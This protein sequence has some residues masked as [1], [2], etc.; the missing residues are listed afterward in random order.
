M[1][2]Y[3]LLANPGHNRV[4]FEQSKQ[5]AKEELALLCMSGALSVSCDDIR[6][7]EIAGIFYLTFRCADSLRPPDTEL[8]SALSFVYAIFALDDE[9]RFI[10]VCKTAKMYIDASICSILKYTGKTNEIFTKLLINTALFSS[11]FA[12]SDRISLLD[13]VAGKGTTLFEGLTRGYDVYGTEIS[14]AS[15]HDA[16]VYLKKYLETEKIKHTLHEERLSGENKAFRALRHTFRIARS[17]EEMKSGGVTFEMVEGSAAYCRSFYKKNFFHIIAGDLPYGIKH[18]NVSQGSGNV[19]QHSSPTRNPSELTRLCA[20]GWYEVLMPGGC[21]AL[22][23]NSFLISREELGE[24]LRKA[25]F[26]VL[27][28]GAYASLEHRVD[29]S[30][31]RDIIVAKKVI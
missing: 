6:G 5:L 9:G 22:S 30:I 4:Y 18:G 8:I 20:R 12:A 10:P 3:A 17:K 7:E 11:D 16:C 2:K 29:S 23:W 28:G 27:D 24:I 15:V 1:V 14:D 26:T 31:K 13:P 19:Q 21:L 25:G